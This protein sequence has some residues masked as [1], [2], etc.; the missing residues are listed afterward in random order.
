MNIGND[1][2]S[3]LK[4]FI[5][6]NNLINYISKPTRI[7]KKK[8]KNKNNI[9]TTVSSTTIDLFIHKPDDDVRT[10]VF[11]CPFSDHRFIVASLAFQRAKFVDPISIGRSLSEKN[12]EIF[13]DLLTCTDF[14]VINKFPNIND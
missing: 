1:N 2:P 6:N 4:E 10:N 3:I 14:S 9:V 7:A 5:E 13:E 12:L 11:G 8:K